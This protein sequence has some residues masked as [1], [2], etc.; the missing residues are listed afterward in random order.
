MTEADYKMVIEE[1]ERLR[2]EC[3]TP[4]KAKDQLRSEGLLD[5]TGKTADLYREPITGIAC[6]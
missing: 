5:A 4:D 1:I 2:L 3:D 6:Q